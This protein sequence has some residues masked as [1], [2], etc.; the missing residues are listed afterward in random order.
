M[1]GD[2]QEE[3]KAFFEMAGRNYPSKV[4]HPPS[5]HDC[6]VIPYTEGSSR[7]PSANNGFYQKSKPNRYPQPSNTQRQ[8]HASSAG[9]QDRTPKEDTDTNDTNTEVFLEDED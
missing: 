6:D 8:P 4:V 9:Q 3:G 7:P 5:S 1:L 2:D